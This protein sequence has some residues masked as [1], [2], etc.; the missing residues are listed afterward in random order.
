MLCDVEHAIELER[1][2]AQPVRSAKGRFAM[3]IDD[4]P[5]APQLAV[6]FSGSKARLGSSKQALPDSA[7]FGF[8]AREPKLG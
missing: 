8:P 1:L 7:R 5:A 2:W 4:L 3:A 6:L